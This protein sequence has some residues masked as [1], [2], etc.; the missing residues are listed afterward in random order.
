MDKKNN[1]TSV[2]IEH[3]DL[4]DALIEL[5]DLYWEKSMTLEEFLEKKDLYK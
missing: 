3:S 5:F 4:T 2:V 1:F